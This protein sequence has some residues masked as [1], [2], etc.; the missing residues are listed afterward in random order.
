[1]P[2]APH[3]SAAGFVHEVRFARA[4]LVTSLKASVALRGAFLLQA[5]F[6]ALNN[7]LVFTTWWILFQRFEQ[8]RGYRI[9]DMLALFGVGAAGFG[10]AMVLCGGGMVELSRLIAE[11]ELDALLSQPKSVLLRALASRSHASGW[12]DLVSGIIMLLL[13]G[14][15][16]AAHLPA[17]LSAVALS[18]FAFV[19]SAVVVHSAAFWL[20]RT[21][22]ISRMVLGF[23]LA[24]ALYPPSLFTG[25]LKILLFTLIPAGLVAYLPVELVRDFRWAT[26]GVATAAVTLY[27]TFAW[28]AFSRGLR[29]YESGSRFG[30]WG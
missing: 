1:M 20:G 10:A 9:A 8:I 4:L 30:V 5:G 11:G 24:F 21:E 16:T 6:M 19:A 2:R 27:G 3:P 22:S 25:G 15:L 14:Y 28:L 17:A 26:A 12:G 23:V 29:R 13:S 7:V 18:A